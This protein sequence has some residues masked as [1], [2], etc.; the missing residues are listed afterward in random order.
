MGLLENNYISKATGYSC[1][2]GVCAVPK[3]WPSSTRIAM[4]GARAAACA[5]TGSS[6]ICPN[7]REA[8]FVHVKN[9]VYFPIVAFTKC[10]LQ[11]IAHTNR[12]SKLDKFLQGAVTLC[13]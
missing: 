4:L 9:T 8:L 12:S 7:E 13:I 6:P 11:L 1:P 5:R 10:Y 2:G 3:G